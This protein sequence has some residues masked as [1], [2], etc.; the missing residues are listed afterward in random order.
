[1]ST[2]PNFFEVLVNNK[3]QYAG[4][5][6]SLIGGTNIIEAGG[7]TNTINI[8]NLPAG[9]SLNIDSNGSDT[10]N[11]TNLGSGVQTILGSIYVNNTQLNGTTLNVDDTFDSAGRNAMLRT[12]GFG[13]IG[14]GSITGL[15]P[16]TINYTPADLSALI[17]T[18][19]PWGNRFT[20]NGTGAPTTLISGRGNDTVTVLATGTSGP[21]NI[22]GVAGQDSVTIG[23]TTDGVQEIFGAVNVSNNGG[24]TDL[25]VD[26]RAATVAKP[27]FGFTTQ[28]AVLINEGAITG[29]A[30]GAITYAQSDLSSLT[31]YGGSYGNIFTIGNTPSNGQFPLST[32]LNSGSGA[33]TVRVL[34]TSGPLNINGVD[35]LDTVTIGDPVLG[36]QN[37][38]G[39]VS[40]TNPATRA[41]SWSTSCCI[42]QAWSHKVSSTWPTL[43]AARATTSSS[44]TPMPTS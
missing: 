32:T 28:S 42:R 19:D 38:L 4:L 36:V 37:I 10:V 2:N 22:N 43:L 14:S 3:R 34:A 7:G 5:W 16:G 9:I 6:S 25:T 8:Q 44:A 35:G 41:I 1:M 33:D 18:A 30:A 23:N 24:F 20:I 12:S 27:S 15:A 13:G 40:V 31:I 11:I 21:L 29:L 26:D 39:A 17:V